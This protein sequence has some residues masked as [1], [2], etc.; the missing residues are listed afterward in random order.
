MFRDEMAS[1]LSKIFGFKKVTFDAPAVSSSGT[2]EQETLFIELSEPNM[3]VTNGKAFG[4]IIGSLVV[5]AQVD[6]MPYGYFAKRIQQADKSLT[7]PFFF[8]DIDL[9]PVSSP[10]RFQNITERRV[11]FVYLYSAQYDPSHGSLT[12]IEGI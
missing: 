10:A 2:F 7:K 6:K 9:N 1:T 8:Y 3:R 4:K 5:F 11:R 12:S